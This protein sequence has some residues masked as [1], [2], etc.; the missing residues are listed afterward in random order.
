MRQRLRPFAAAVAMLLAMAMPAAAQVYTGRIDLTVTDSTG[1]VLPGVTVELAG[2]ANRTAVSDA[3]GEAR[4]LNLPPGTYTVT[5]KLQGF[6]DYSNPNVAVVAG[7]SVP[8]RVTMA[9]AGMAAAVEVTAET[10][11][12]D[13]KRMTTSTNVTNEQLQEIPSSRDPWVVLQT[14]PG[15]IVDRVNVGGAESG[16]QSG[17]QAKGSSGGENTWSIDGIQITDMAATGASPTYYDFDM[18]QEMNVTTGGADL[19]SA[20]GGV[21][22]N[23]VLKSG[24]NTPRGSARVYYEN[25]S[26]Q[27]T[28]IPDDLAASLGGATGKGNRMDEYTDYGAELGG[29]ILR[30]RLWAWGAYGKTDVTVL[31]ILGAPDQTIL[32]NRSFKATGQATQNIR[33]S[34]TYFRG[35]KLKYGRNASSTRPDET[36]WNQTG[37]TGVNKGELNLVLGNNLFLTGRGAHVAGGFGLYPRGGLETAWYTDDDGVNHGSFQQA[38]YDRPQWTVSADGN[39][40]RGRHEVKFGVGFRSTESGTESVIPGYGGNSG[41]HTSH[42]GYPL[43]DADVW[44]PSSSRTNSDYLFAFLGDTITWDRLTLNVGVRWDRQAAGVMSTTQAG[45]PAFSSL[46]PD[47]TSEAVNDAIVYTSLTPRIGVTYALNDRRTTIARASYAMFADQV[48]TGAAGFLST[49]GSRG[50]YVYDVVDANGNQYADIAEVQAKLAENGGISSCTNTSLTCNTYG[51]DPANP[52]ASSGSAHTI[53]DYGTPMTHEFQLGLDHELMPNFGVSGTFTFRH[54]NNFNWRN[55]G[56][57]GNDYQQIGTYEGTAPGV[58]DFSTPIFGVIPANIPANSSATEFRSRPDYSQRYIGFEAAATKRLSNKWMARFGFSTNRHTEYY[59]SPASHQNP[60][61]GVTGGVES[62]QLVVRSSGG[63]GKSGI[64][65]VLPLYQF[66]ATGMYQAPFGINLAANMV[67]RQGF[68][69]Q[70][71]RSRVATSDPLGRSKTVSIINENGEHRL[72][73]VTSLDF[74]LGKEFRVQRARL[75]IDLDVFNLLNSAT[76]LGREYDFRLGT[77]DN[78]REIMNPRILRLGLRVGF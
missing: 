46:L 54:F 51:F 3:S 76:V 14:V 15:I 49:V 32:D 29:P 40:F 2:A 72:P 64:Y 38:V 61:R 48:G 71:Y 69:K 12:I 70:Y 53:G 35:D 10:P 44:V 41:I 75:N 4:F 16:Q 37:P 65:Q 19:N 26:M 39:Y 1:A 62:G 78:V 67:T 7:S 22:L 68:A 42:N 36:T 74:R 17:Y 52:A 23:F 63:S 45:F 27:A 13:P 25:E 30:D 77:F 58:G 5:A 50:F 11:V 60:T 6:N 33:G 24:S 8:L 56:L 73:T 21:G 66:I 55:N 34:Y 59:D 18:F 31:T 9:V 28:N 43:M 20:T 57:D 47:L